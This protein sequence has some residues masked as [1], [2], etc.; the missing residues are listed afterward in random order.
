LLR[1]GW[2][3]KE[4]SRKI[5][6]GTRISAKNAYNASGMMMLN[7][8]IGLLWQKMTSKH[9][10]LHGAFIMQERLYM[11]INFNYSFTYNGDLAVYVGT[12]VDSQYA[13][14][15]ESFKLF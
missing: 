2:L 5:Y 10:V 11:G 14:M 8:R 3:T 1:I 7:K 6:A 4:R 13:K 15:P 9:R 12:N